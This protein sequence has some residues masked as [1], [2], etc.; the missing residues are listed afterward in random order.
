MVYASDVDAAVAERLLAVISTEEIKLALA[1]AKEVQ[2]REASRSRSFE[3]QV[4][5]AKYEAGRAERAFHCCDPENRLVARTLE[6]R[7]EEKLQLLVDAEV[8]YAEDQAAKVPLPSMKDLESLAEDFSRLWMAPSTSIKDRK[9]ILRILVADVTVMSQ[10]AP[11][12]EI[13]VGIHWQSGATEEVIVNRPWLPRRR[14]PEDVVEIVRRLSN[15]TDEEIAKELRGAGLRTGGHRIFT[16]KSV[17]RIRIKYR[18][19]LPSFP[20]DNREL[21]VMDFAWQFQVD[22]NTVYYWIHRG[23]IQGRQCADGRIRIPFTPEIKQA[24]QDRVAGSQSR[25]SKIQN[26]TAREAV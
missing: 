5:R 21:T 24:C 20:D 23:Y 13:R 8:A 26:G 15:C 11:G 9:R 12:M 18:L 19:P 2:A 14:T 3:L 10:P 6:H 22:K 4:E 25:K 1:A 17:R 7:W 16:G